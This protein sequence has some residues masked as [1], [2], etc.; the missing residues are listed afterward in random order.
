MRTG[1][2]GDGAHG[3][4]WVVDIGK[5]TEGCEYLLSTLAVVAVHLETA[6]T[7][8]HRP[9]IPAP[10][11]GAGRRKQHLLQRTC[12]KAAVHSI[13]LF[14]GCPTVAP[15]Q[16]SL[17][18]IEVAIFSGNVKNVYTSMSEQPVFGGSC[19]GVTSLQLPPGRSTSCSAP[20]GMSRPLWED[21][22]IFLEDYVTDSE[23]RFLYW[24]RFRDILGTLNREF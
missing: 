5:P 14:R 22:S 7:H 13:A 18:Q 17:L 9:W 19:Q 10:L 23:K 21:G 20:S 6:L 12:A 8:P 24:S 11:F 1:T 16:K 4:E 3:T 15:K 2:H